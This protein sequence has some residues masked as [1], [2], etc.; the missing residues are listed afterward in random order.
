MPEALRRAAEHYNRGAYA[1]VP[2]CCERVPADHP[3]GAFAANL[4]GMAHFLTGDEATAAEDFEEALRRDPGFTQ[5]YLGKG[6]VLK[7]R[8]DLD[9]AESAYRRLIEAGLA[10]APVHSGLGDVHE[11]RGELDRA[12]EHFEAALGFTPDHAIAR[13]KVGNCLMLKGEPAKALPHLEAA[14][15]ADPSFVQ[16]YSNLQACALR[17]GD[18]DAVRDACARCRAVDPSNQFS[19]AHEAFAAMLDGDRA[20]FDELY[21][22]RRFPHRIDLGAVPGYP[23]LASFN[24]QLHDDVL[25][26][27]SLSWHHADAH[28]TTPRGFAYGLLDEPTPAVTAFAEELRRQ[29]RRFMD[30]LPEVAGHPML[31]AKPADFELAM[32]ATIL[33]SGGEHPAH[34]HEQAWLSGVYYCSTGFMTE[35]PEDERAGWIRFAGFEEYSRSPEDLARVRIEEPREGTMF[36]FPSYFLHQTIPFH[37]E[38]HRISIAFDVQPR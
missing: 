23:D 35:D 32:W 19:I 21:D 25:A 2:A 38:G 17:V 1:E 6:N 15:A 33:R 3:Y 26:H 10:D 29:V 37:V 20:R 7:N 28:R 27:P 5:A 30:E 13:Y 4:A 8:G 11:R 14:V 24:R 18:S 9:G 34:S 31:G 12:L 22:L 16:A 36:L